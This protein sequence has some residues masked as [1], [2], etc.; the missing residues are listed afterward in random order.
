M[1]CMMWG[2][3]E[4][5]VGEKKKTG[6]IGGFEKTRIEKNIFLVLSESEHW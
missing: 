5:R 2:W 4:R 1:L 3:R 6:C